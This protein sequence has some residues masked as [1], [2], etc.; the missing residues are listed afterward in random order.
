ML[1]ADVVEAARKG[2]LQVFAAGDVDEG[3]TILTGIR[4]GTR[5]DAA[6]EPSLNRQI[7]DRLVAFSRQPVAADAVRT[8]AKAATP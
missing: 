6:G 5:T 4:A 3:L 1:R 8:T 2:K 7:E